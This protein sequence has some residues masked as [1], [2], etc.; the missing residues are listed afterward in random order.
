MELNWFH[1]YVIHNLDW[2]AAVCTAT[3][4]LMVG[5]K[6]RAGWL[7]LQAGSCGWFTVGL[8]GLYGGRPI[9]AQAVL[10]VWTSCV[11]MWAW[12]RWGK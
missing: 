4:A 7:V 11:N 10:S 8:L 3:G 6:K 2:V 12:W 5:Q 9:W 1:A